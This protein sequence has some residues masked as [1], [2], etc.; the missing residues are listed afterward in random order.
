MINF[1]EISQKGHNIARHIY[2]C[3][4]RLYVFLTIQTSLFT[5]QQRN[6]TIRPKRFF[7]IG[8]RS[9]Q[10]KN[11]RALAFAILASYVFHSEGIGEIGNLSSSQKNT[12]VNFLLHQAHGQCMPCG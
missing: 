1:E 9:L 3:E 2:I 6:S 7:R 11:Q 5:T 4:S 8:D 10:L 12:H